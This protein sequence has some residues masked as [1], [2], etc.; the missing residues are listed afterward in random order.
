[1]ERTWV[2]NKIDRQLNGWRAYEN[3]SNPN[4][5]IGEE[6]ILDD[7]LRLHDRT[8]SDD[9]GMDVVGGIQNLRSSLSVPGAS[10]RL[11][12]LSGVGKTRLV[13]ALFDERLGKQA[14]S[15]SQ[16]FYTDISFSPKPDPKTFAEQLIA[17]KIRAILIIDNCPPD[18]HRL[19]TKTCSVKDSNVNLLT[20]EYDVRDDI[21]EETSVFMLEPASENII[22]KLIRNRFKHISQVDAQTIAKFSGGNARIAVSL[23]NT[24]QVGES[25]SGFRDE[26]L[27][28]RLFQ[29]RHNPNENLLISAEACSLVYS[30]EGTDIDSDESELKLLASIIDKPVKELYRDIA[31]LKDRDLVQSRNVW[32]AVL[33]QAIADRLAKRALSSIPKD[34][35]V[36]T[37]TKKGSKRLIISFARRLEYL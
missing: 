31:T 36:S 5:G 18:L 25:L 35:L 12:G 3:W 19:M 37:I 7:G 24:L 23:A 11:A 20:V 10:V 28:E 21:P 22:E 1:L 14:L 8:K 34:S 13:Q 15:P 30:F 26:D 17:G 33:P 9:K 29:Q 4:A 32:R 16:A 6:Y 27:F 2:R